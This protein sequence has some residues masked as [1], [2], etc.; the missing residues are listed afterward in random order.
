MRGLLICATGNNRPVI[1]VNQNST[2]NKSTRNRKIRRKTSDVPQ[3][4]KQNQGLNNIIVEP[5]K[6]SGIV[7]KRNAEIDKIHNIMDGDETSN[8]VN[9]L[10]Q[11]FVN[12]GEYDITETDKFT[13]HESHVITP[14]TE[15][16]ILSRIDFTDLS[17]FVCALTDSSPLCVLNTSAVKDF[18]IGMS[19]SFLL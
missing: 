13:G 12:G 16:R 18:S 3:T 8:A 11:E 1:P 6:L 2:G 7:M 5:Y 14:R 10:V 4:T 9:H 19:I 17:P 15:S